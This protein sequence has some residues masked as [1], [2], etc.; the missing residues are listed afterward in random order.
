MIYLTEPELIL[1]SGN[2]QHLAYILRSIYKHIYD[3]NIQIKRVSNSKRINLKQDFSDK[4]TSCECGAVFL[5]NSICFHLDIYITIKHL[6]LCQK[7]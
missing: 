4:F 5:I 2:I 3:I 1:E 6:I 7:M